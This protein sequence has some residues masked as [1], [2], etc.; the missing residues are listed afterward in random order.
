MVEEMK[1]D[2]MGTTETWWNKANDWIMRGVSYTEMLFVPLTGV[3]ATWDMITCKYNK[4][5]QK[6]KVEAW[7]KEKK[8]A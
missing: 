4:L 8:E 5:L 1:L 7:L 3:N 2:S 6:K